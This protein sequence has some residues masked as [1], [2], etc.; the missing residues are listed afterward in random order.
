MLK[1]G[2]QTQAAWAKNLIQDTQS[3]IHV[4][5]V[6][7]LRV[8]STSRHWTLCFRKRGVASGGSKQC[9]LKCRGQGR[10]L[11]CLRVVLPIGM[12]P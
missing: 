9:S 12:V 1:S 11:S 2:R 8:A 6:G 10:G 3:V 5:G 7:K 4:Q